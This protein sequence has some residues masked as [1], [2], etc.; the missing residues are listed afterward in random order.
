[1]ISVGQCYSDAH[2]VARAAG[3]A[4]RDARDAR[5]SPGPDGEV[6]VEAGLESR[7]A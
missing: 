6:G 1:M 2:A 7:S 4:P 3:Y 5:A